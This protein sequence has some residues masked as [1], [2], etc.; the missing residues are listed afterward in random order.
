MH[1]D[2]AATESMQNMT[3]STTYTSISSPHAGRRHVRSQA[4]TNNKL[5]PSA[6]LLSRQFMLGTY[7]V[8][9]YCLCISK[10]GSMPD[11]IAHVELYMIQA[12][13]QPQLVHMWTAHDTSHVVSCPLLTT[14]LVKTCSATLGHQHNTCKRQASNK[15]TL[16]NM[17]PNVR[18]PTIHI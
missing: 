5:A 18:A 2:D 1:S 12:G 9:L 8:L 11:D 16:S 14:A 7:F 17:Q 10:H 3:S 13:Q 4:Q 15:S 6:P